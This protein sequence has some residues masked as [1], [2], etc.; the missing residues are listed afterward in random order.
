MHHQDS[1]EIMQF[2]FQHMTNLLSYDVVFVAVAY[3]GNT[4]PKQP[5][6]KN[7]VDNLDVKVIM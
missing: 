1:A 7:T 2:G 3:M 6:F 4:Q 5:V